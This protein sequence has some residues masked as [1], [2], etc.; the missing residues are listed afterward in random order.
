[1]KITV[2]ENFQDRKGNHEL[3]KVL[4]AIKEGK[5]D[6]ETTQLREA[7]SEEE[8]GRIK[9]SLL[10][11]T[12]SVEL[13]T[14][15][16]FTE[17][18]RYSSII[19]LDYDKLE[20][21]PRALKKIKALDYTY[22]C[23]ISPSGNGI[24]VF[25]R[26]NNNKEQHE[27]AFNTLKSYYDKAVGVES[28][29]SIKDL[30][31]LCYVSSDP[32]LYI[33]EESQVFDYTTI[34]MTRTAEELWEY[35]SRKETFTVG[36]RN[37]FIHFFACNAN[38][39]GLDIEEVKSYCSSHTDSTLTYQEIERTIR[40]AYENNTSQFGELQSVQFVQSCSKEDKSPMIPEEVYENLPPTLKESCK[41]FSGRERDVYLTSALSVVSGGLS[42]IKGVYDNDIVYPNLYSFII[43]PAASGKGSMKY[44]KSLGDCYHNLLQEQNVQAKI[45]YNRD[46]EIYNLKKKMAKKEEDIVDLKKPEKP[47]YKAFFIAGNISSAMLHKVLESNSGSGCIT[48][49][50]TDTIT[51][52]LKQE[53]GGYSDILRKGFHHETISLMRKTDL[54]YIIIE[55][56][57]FSLS[58]TGTPDQ[59]KGILSNTKNGLASRFMFYSFNAKPEWRRTFTRNI[60]S[61]KQNQFL[62]FTQDLCDKFSSQSEREFNI[63]EEQGEI[64]FNTFKEILDEKYY[65]YLG[66]SDS[67]IKRLGL[68]IYKIAMVLSA[69]RTDEPIME[70]EDRDFE[71]AMELTKVYLAHGLNVFEKI[72]NREN[73]LPLNEERWMNKLP[74]EFTSSEA[75]SIA[76]K[77]GIKERTVY[78]KLRDYVDNELLKKV[79]TGLYRKLSKN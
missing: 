13:N 26:V 24:K 67:L 72:N 11:F 69:V 46:V 48:E 51:N 37:N 32:D 42:N 70:C 27:D 22:S 55:E 33:N 7:D 59:V 77:L 53:W 14:G 79:K 73:K 45:N 36:N 9:N 68:I 31:R 15:R 34:S 64:H 5:F 28:D 19:H 54:E 62:K 1:M 30:C 2:F 17:G 8:K 10:A 21:V 41:V 75:I 58:I 56:P 78:K 38:R 12:P 43:A 25:V 74:K 3:V 50:E 52:A 35:T 29:K 4:N 40:S 57:K 61:S 16:T 65:S 39:E 76:K 66:E 71:T 23:F 47:K 60:S 49:T 6:K 18:D 44:A 20:D 63:T